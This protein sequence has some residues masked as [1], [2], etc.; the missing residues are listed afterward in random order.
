MLTVH[1]M[2][3]VVKYLECVVQ[4]LVLACVVCKQVITTLMYNAGFADT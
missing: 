2:A 4:V 3:V 1:C